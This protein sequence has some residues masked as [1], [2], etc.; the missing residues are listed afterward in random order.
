MSRVI[1]MFVIICSLT[2]MIHCTRVFNPD[3]EISHLSQEELL[4][5][6]YQ[7]KSVDKLNAFFERWQAEIS[8][9]TDSEYNN[10]MPVE[11]EI[12]KIHK[13]IFKPN[14]EN[15]IRSVNGPS[16]SIK[17]KSIIIIQDR[18]GYIIDDSLRSL[19]DLRSQDTIHY[20]IVNFRPN[21]NIPDYSVVYL[22]R[23][24]ETILDNFLGEEFG[25]F[26]EGSVMNPSH[27]RGESKLRHQ[28]LELVVRIIPG[29]WG[30]YWHFATHPAIGYI[31]INSELTRALLDYRAGWGGRSI[32]LYREGEDW[33]VGK[34]GYIWME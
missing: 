33:V 29:H 5:I 13:T 12:Y 24:Y 32:E 17:G 8:P 27:P 14:D 11:K 28:F 30:G 16:I 25:P 21:M 1:R 15:M 20:P 6:A 18:F 23:K 2:L 31:T 4:G 7:E 34:T 26:G 19:M 10:L 3:E 9:I 22:T